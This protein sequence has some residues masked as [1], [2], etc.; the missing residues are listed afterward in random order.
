MEAP[1]AFSFAQDPH[2]PAGAGARLDRRTFLR[3]SLALAGGCAVCLGPARAAEAERPLK[4][5]GQAKGIHPGRVV[6]A[7][8]PNIIHWKGPGDGHWW[9]GSRVDQALVHAMLGQ[10]LVQLTGEATLASAWRQLF[11]HLNN[12]RG[13]GDVGY[14]PGEKIAIK[15]NW[16][17]LISGDGNVSTDNYTLT[18]RL[19]YMNT[20]PQMVLALLYSLVSAGVREAD[21]TVCDTLACLVDDYYGILR[22]RVHEPNYRELPEVH[23]QDCAGKFGREQ[24]KPSSIPLHWS[25]RPQGKAQDFLPTF[26]AEAEYAINFAAFKAH[27]AAGVTLCAKNHFGSLARKPV[28]AGY[29]DLHA[30][31]FATNSGGY[32]PVVDLMGHDHLGGKTVLYLI[33]GLFSGVH[34]RDEV[35]QRMKVAPFDGQW[36]CS[37][38]V[39][40]DPVAIDSVA[41]DFLRTEWPEFAGKDGVDDYL[42]EAALADNPPSGAFYDPNHAKATQRLSS[43]GVHEH[44]NNAREKQ[45]SRNLKTDA[46]IE[47][48]ALE[49][50]SHG[51]LR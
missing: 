23:Y 7:H 33:D 14:R 24:V 28:Q 47:L 32:R 10:S 4:P 9:A 18:A 40:Q 43:L 26:F 6:W 39:S 20:A 35:P 5:I 49:L 21:I 30:A 12:S 3:R 46:G 45:Y 31:S 15:P 25:S 17:G 16:V 1:L 44:W 22:N 41:L 29:Y 27:T 36:P 13:K 11:R 48:V 2:R 37:L 38:F 34:P 19:D 42:H 8:N 50:S 51:S